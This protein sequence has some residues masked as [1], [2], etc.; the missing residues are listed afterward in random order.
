MAYQEIVSS[1]KR[2]PLHEQFLLVEELLREMRQA[3]KPPTRR[4]R[5]RVIPFTRL[6][7]ALKPDGP[8]PSDAQLQDSYT[9]YLVEKY[10]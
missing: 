7:G 3:A 10:L 4:N 1:A 9:E 5:T 8:L 2:L 6:R